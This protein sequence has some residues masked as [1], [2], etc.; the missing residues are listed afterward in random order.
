MESNSVPGQPGRPLAVENSMDFGLKSFQ[1]P[2]KLLNG[3]YLAISGCLFWPREGQGLSPESLTL[4]ES[5]LGPLGC[6]KIH[7]KSILRPKRDPR[8]RC[9]MYLCTECCFSDFGDRFFM[10]FWWKIDAKNYVCFQSS[11]CF[12]PPGEP[13]NSSTGAVFWALFV[14]IILLKII[15]QLPKK[16]S[17]IKIPKKPR[18][19]SPE[20]SQNGSKMA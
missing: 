18:K 15:E 11:V 7:Q 4:L 6:L 1:N 8:D 14:F 5:F 13:L 17:K 12:F 10:I 3:R 2:W 19:M 9:L 16:Q 20:A